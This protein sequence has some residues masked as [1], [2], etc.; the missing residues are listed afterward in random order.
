[1]TLQTSPT[2]SAF[3]HI[4]APNWNDGRVG[5]GRATIK[6]FADFHLSGELGQAVD[7][8]GY[9]VPTPVQAGCIPLA[10]A[11]IDLIVQSPT[12]SGK[13]AAFAIPTLEQL[14]PAARVEALVLCPTRE[15]ARQVAGEFERL[16]KVK[17]IAVTT[18]YGGTGFT[19]Q[20][21]ELKTAQVVCA[22]PGRL[23]DLM[24]RGALTLDHLKVFIL[25][26]AD[27][28][29]NM[30]FEKELDAIVERLPGY[31]QNLLFSATVTE[32]IKNLAAH[33]LTY[34]EFLSF[35]EDHVVVADVSHVL[36]PITGLDRL[37]DLLKVMEFE[38]PDNGIIFANTKDDTFSVTSFLKKHGYNAEV[39]NGDLPQNERE[40]TLAK[41]RKG[42]IDFLVATDVA[43]RGI[44]ISDLSHVF[45]FALPESPE[46]YVHRTGRTGRAGK[47]GVAISLLSP[48]EIG[49]YYLLRRIYKVEF[50]ERE[51]PARDQIR[52]RKQERALD[53]VLAR[54]DRHK[55]L[56][57]GD[58]LG[59]ADAIL[60]SEDA[61]V[62]VAKL[63]AAFT[64][65]NPDLLPNAIPPMTPVRRD[66]TPKRLRPVFLVP[67][68]PAP[69]AE[70]EDEDE[71]EPWEEETPS[72]EPAPKPSPLALV[73]FDEDDDDDEDEDE[74]EKADE[75]EDE[76]EDRQAARAPRTQPEVTR[77]DRRG[78]DRNPRGE[79]R[80]RDDRPERKSREERGERKDR[81]DRPERKDREE[82]GERKDR[83][84]RPER[85]SREEREDRPERKDREERSE[86]KDRDD[87]PERKDREERPERK[88][89]EERGERKDR[90]ERPERKDRKDRDDQ[91]ERKD[92][93]ERGERKERKDRDDRGER[94][95]RKDRDDQGERKDREERG[96]RKD[97]DDRPERKERK[98]RDDRPER[99]DR[100]E[101]SERK[102]RD[103]RPERKDRKDR[104]EQ[105]E[106]KDREERSERK[107]S[108]DDER[109]EGGRERRGRR[110]ERAERAA[111][112]AA[113]EVTETTDSDARSER[114]R[115]DRQREQSWEVV[116]VDGPIDGDDDDDYKARFPGMTKLHLNVGSGRLSD[117]Q[118]VVRMVCDIA[119]I[120]PADCGEVTLRR[121]FSYILVREEI[122][123]DII[124]RISGQTHAGIDLK[125]AIARR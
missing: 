62:C 78:P 97:R 16:G 71:D 81:D 102:D 49:V 30:G 37:Q 106:R 89:R 5:A 125:A 39:L 80:D 74:D 54:L 59:F 82:R 1:M 7:A 100:E 118:S 47:S 26:E 34:P 6:T 73:R 98:D 29:L 121:R 107:E 77:D 117:E 52:A 33:I 2:S 63:L 116:D 87:R 99:K 109:P 11:G 43:A 46:T 70:D 35:S 91:G 61:R 123:H 4:K 120:L 76:D 84:D 85:K 20:I 45:N 12:G 36:Y 112:P 25:D 67:P 93:E 122:A 53:R 15:L 60:S 8:V 124:A 119:G 56:A 111:E 38:T 28:M 27:E 13:T 105:G 108:T 65:A 55:A 17:G 92:R 18:V 83:D 21:S 32:E 72:A 75:D 90:Q 94:K 104:D 86:R 42:S 114:R 110:S 115:A 88:D 24:S 69:L 103:D 95:E 101:R 3:D 79:R 23:L 9:V 44:D 68:T 113:E 48:R 10:I 22:T 51:M 58:Q 14:E 31:R 40:A 66:A 64:Q 96:E 57:Y 50:E 41:L 19:Q